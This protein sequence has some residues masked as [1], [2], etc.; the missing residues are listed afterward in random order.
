M[1]KIKLIPDYIDTTIIKNEGEREVFEIFANSEDTEDWI[2]LHSLILPKHI[3]Q[4]F[5]EI[6]FV[7]LAPNLGIF[8]LEVKNKSFSY[9]GKMHYVSYNRYGEYEEKQVNPFMQSRNNSESLRKYFPKES[10]IRRLLFGYGLMFPSFPF[11]MERIEFEPEIVYDSNSKQRPISDYIK[12]LSNYFKYKFKN[13]G[14]IKDLPSL[15]QISE[16]AAQL[17]HSF[18]LSIVE[19]ERLK[20]TKSKIIDF[21][22]E[23]SR[24]IDGFDEC[25]RMLFKGPPGSGKTIL[26]TYSARRSVMKSKRLLFFSFNKLIGY[27]VQNQFRNYK[28]DYDFYAGPFNDYLE[29]LIGKNYKD[30]QDQYNIH[31][32]YDD[33]LPD[34]VINYLQD[35]DFKKYNYLIIDDA[36]DIFR[37]KYIKILNLL[38]KGGFKKG[39]W[40]LYCDFDSQNIFLK[41]IDIKSAIGKAYRDYN[42]YSLHTNYRNCKK[43]ANEISRVFD[44]ADYTPYKNNDEGKDPLYVYYDTEEEGVKK[45]ENI[46]KRIVDNKIPSNEITILSAH[47]SPYE[48]NNSLVYSLDPKIFKIDDISLDDNLFFRTKNINFCSIYRFKGMENSYIIIIDVDKDMDLDILNNLLCT[49]MSRAQFSLTVLVNNNIRARFEELVKETVNYF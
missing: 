33:V 15:Q 25:P 36:Q 8:S 6:D 10:P 47:L 20:L 14:I 9:D 48:N 29:F 35:T 43:I 21:S 27:Q 46:L 11:K 40:Q 3:K 7:V 22:K 5:G 34:L 49:G 24:I 1:A 16:I 41:D 13:L 4:D 39:N 32:Y 44:L 2:V 19:Y 18:E 26:A 17:R 31:Q 12:T 28:K 42:T 38:L 37:E 45:L 30:F 23:Q